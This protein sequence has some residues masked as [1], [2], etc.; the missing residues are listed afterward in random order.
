VVINKVGTT[1]YANV[2]AVRA[3]VQELNPDA[4]IVDAASP[5]SVD[6]PERIR[7]RRALVI[8]D[9]PTLTHG[10]MQYGAGVIAAKRHG[11]RE[12][13]D[14][15]PWLVGEIR[16]TFRQYPGIGALLPAMGYSDEQL[17]DMERTINACDC[18]VVVIATPI[19]LR[20]LI[21]IKHPTVRVGYELEEIGRPKL[22]DVIGEFLAERSARRPAARAASPASGSRRA[23]TRGRVARAAKKPAPK[24]ARSRGSRPRKKGRGRR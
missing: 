21:D 3:S 23:A 5:I 4:V 1:D 7:G 19:D 10:E 24:P 15:R 11:A 13:V 12:I 16:D 18:D 9:G 14:P 6:R 20:R 8:E 17:R 2:E 22:E